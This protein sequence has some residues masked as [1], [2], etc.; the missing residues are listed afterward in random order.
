MKK[1]FSASRSATAYSADDDVDDD[2]FL[3]SSR[4]AKPT[5]AYGRNMGFSTDSSSKATYQQRYDILEDQKTQLLNSKKEIESRTLESTQRSLSLL[6]DSEDV[7]IATAEVIV[8]LNMLIVYVALICLHGGFFTLSSYRT[9]TI[10]KLH[11]LHF[12][13]ILALFPFSLHF[14]FHFILLCF[15]MEK[16]LPYVEHK[17]KLGFIF[18]ICSIGITLKYF[19]SFASAHS[20]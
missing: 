12:Q 15:H 19:I 9:M 8:C 20:L 16:I 10:R 2:T 5:P 18:V 14:C 1:R 7:G 17:V 11:V 13:I 4:T 6:R 3:N